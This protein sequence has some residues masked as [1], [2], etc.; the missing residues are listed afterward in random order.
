M[1]GPVRKRARAEE[2]I[3]PLPASSADPPDPIPGSAEPAGDAAAAAGAEVTATL[4]P[5]LLALP[6]PAISIADLLPNPQNPRLPWKPEQLAPFVASLRT[7]GDLGGIVRN[8]TTNHLVG[9][10]KRVEVFRESGAVEIHAHPQMPDAQGT[11]S[12]GYVLVDGMRFSYREVEWPEEREAAANLAANRWA[13]QWDWALVSDTL[14]SITD[15]ELLTMTGFADHELA[16]LLAADWNPAAVGSL[17]GARTEEHT[18]KL[19][20]AQY[21]LLRSAGERLTTD[22]GLEDPLTDALAIE[23]LCSRFLGTS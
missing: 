15:T 14:R 3:P 16:N 20:A 8:R 22:L 18:I 13:A 2:R 12:V 5:L 10:H 6:V 17:D 9:G 11:V 1:A 19:T 23:H 4:T 21:A 7:F